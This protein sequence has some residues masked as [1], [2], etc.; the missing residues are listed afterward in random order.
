MIQARHLI[1]SDLQKFQATFHTKVLTVH[2]IHK[3]SLF[4]TEAHILARLSQSE[5]VAGRSKELVRLE[6]LEAMESRWWHESHS[7]HAFNRPAWA[8]MVV[9][10]VHLKQLA[11]KW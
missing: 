4:T 5:V 3:G 8:V 9:Q 6:P 2:P 1:A 11:S 10:S 7:L